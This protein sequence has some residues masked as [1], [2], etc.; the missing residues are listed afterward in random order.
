MRSTSGPRARSKRPRRLGRGQA[1]AL[2]LAARSR[3]GRRGRPAAGAVAAGGAI[4]C[5]GPAVAAPR[6][7]VRSASWRR[8]DLGR[9]RQRGPR[10]RAG[11][12]A[13]SGERHVV[14]RAAGLQ[15]VEEPEPLLG[16]GERQAVAV[17]R[18][19]RRRLRRR[20]RRAP[21]RSRPPRPAPRRVGASKR[22]R[23]GSSTPKAARAR[24]TSWVARSEWPPSSKKLSSAPTRST[25]STSRPD[26]GQDLLDRGARR[27]VRRPPAAVAPRLRLGSAAGRACRWR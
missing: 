22:R 24:D 4:T 12:G 26:A 18:R 8:D 25:P 20:P 1:G 23:S 7:S 19:R 27:D 16:E 14:G 13:R 17:P 6:T 2:G 15:P 3:A 21:L 11:R 9:A 5:T 10:S